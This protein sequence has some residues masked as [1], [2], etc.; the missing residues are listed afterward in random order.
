MKTLTPVLVLICLAL[1]PIA[2]ADIEITGVTLYRFDGRTPTIRIT[3]DRAPVSVAGLLGNV[4]IDGRSLDAYQRSLHSA[5]P[6]E[7]AAYAVTATLRNISTGDH[8]VRIG[9]GVRGVDG[10]R[11]AHDVQRT[12]RLP[13]V[14]GTSVAFHDSRSVGNRWIG[15]TLAADLDALPTVH[16]DNP[17]SGEAR[18]DLSTRLSGSLLRSEFEIVEVGMLATNNAWRSDGR[19]RIEVYIELFG[20]ELYGPES[21][22]TLSRTLPGFERDLPIVSYSMFGVVEASAG[23][24]VELGGRIAATNHAWGIRNELVYD[25]TLSAFAR[26][27]G[28]IGVAGGGLEATV[29][30]PTPDFDMHFDVD[31]HGVGGSADVDISSFQ[32]LLRAYWWYYAVVWKD[33][34]PVVRRR[35][36]SELLVDEGGQ[37]W[38][39]NL[40]R[41]D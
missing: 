21:A 28:T 23:V 3:L 7:F 1:A 39:W 5:G 31:R 25:T 17:R 19:D 2:R 16:P 20:S 11:T 33:W 8:V 4:E 26:A 12:L 6:G 32:F 36:R 24:G 30:F 34:Y 15:A 41:L 22:T 29:R 27:S 37:A 35:D 18:I 13:A 14:S 9:R 38:N 40:F 10:S